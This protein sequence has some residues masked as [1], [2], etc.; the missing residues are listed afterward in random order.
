MTQ[1]NTTPDGDLERDLF[2]KHFKRGI[3]TQ[4]SITR[5]YSFEMG[6]ALMKHKGKCYNI[7]GHNYRLEV[8]IYARDT[9]PITGMIMDFQELDDIVNPIIKKF[10]HK[11]YMNK[12]DNRIKLVQEAYG[13]EFE[14]TAENLVW[15]FYY[16]IDVE[17]E[18]KYANEFPKV[19][20]IT[21]YETDKASATV[22]ST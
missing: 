16:Q 19:G 17:M 9:N 6:H 21:L 8:E 20:R 10:D 14:P 12:L 3:E 22:F 18:K 2:E 7:H 1:Q 5:E 15:M 13:L 4:I 11:L